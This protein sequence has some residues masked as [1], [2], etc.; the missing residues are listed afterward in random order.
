M[1]MATN[2]GRASLGGGERRTTEEELTSRRSSVDGDERDEAGEL[3]GQAEAQDG[4][5]M[6]G[7]ALKDAGGA[8]VAVVP[9]WRGE[10]P[11]SGRGARHPGQPRQQHRR[12]NQ[13]E[14]RAD[15]GPA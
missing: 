1:A 15:V 4:K 3:K 11:H 8:S 13:Q 14:P 9:A 7:E 2:A 10:R 6:F 5:R 12:P